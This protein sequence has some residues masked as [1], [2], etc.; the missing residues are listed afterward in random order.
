MSDKR[1][2]RFTATDIS[3]EVIMKGYFFTLTGDAV[4][5]A[6]AFQRRYQGMRIKSLSL[7]AK[8]TKQPQYR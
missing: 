5:A 6:A 4:E 3:G 2:W 8:K 1:K 7:V